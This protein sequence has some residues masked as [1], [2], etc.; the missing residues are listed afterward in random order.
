MSCPG[1][2]FS[3]PR[4][5]RRTIHWWK[6]RPRRPP[7]MSTHLPT[8][9]LL[10]VPSRSATSEVVP[11]IVVDIPRLH[12]VDL[13]RVVPH[14]AE[15]P[16]CADARVGGARRGTWHDAVTCVG[17]LGRLRRARLRQESGVVRLMAH[18]GP[19]PPRLRPDTQLPEVCRIDAR[20][21]SFGSGDNPVLMEGDCLRLGLIGVPL[22]T[23]PDQETA[24]W[25][26]AL[27]S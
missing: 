12:A 7:D 18:R 5:A 16:D 4:S 14:S 11:F 24:T 25:T 15:V 10:Q 2:A 3:L 8:F 20:K 23:S 1:S 6:P 22:S 17:A 13:R 19:P 21:E 26:V 27:S 9:R